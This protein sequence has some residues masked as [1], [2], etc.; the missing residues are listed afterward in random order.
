MRYRIITRTSN[1]SDIEK[2]IFIWYKQFT[3]FD[4]VNT[5]HYKN[6][7]ILP[8]FV[9]EPKT[10]STHIVKEDDYGRN[11]VDIFKVREDIIFMMDKRSNTLSYTTMHQLLKTRL[12]AKLATEKFREGTVGYGV[13]ASI[14]T[15]RSIFG[16]YGDAFIGELFN[17]PEAQRI[18]ALPNTKENNLKIARLEY[19]YWNRV[20]DENR[21]FSEDYFGG[22]AGSSF[23]PDSRTTIQFLLGSLRSPN[24]VNIAKDLAWKKI[25]EMLK[26]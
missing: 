16:D 17:S 12:G 20:A 25:N 24:R 13:H 2:A 11:Y 7:T 23:K 8:H 9:N 15:I 18:M 1:I 6:N 26:Q 21:F 10:I 22:A 14:T 3:W 5:I 19:E 4:R